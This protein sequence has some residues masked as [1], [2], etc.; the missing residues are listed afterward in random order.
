MQNPFKIFGLLTLL[1]S[2]SP[3]IS[4]FDDPKEAYE[5]GHAAMMSKDWLDA[6]NAFKK[7]S[8]S[9]KLKAAANYWQAYAHYQLNQNA[10]AKRLLERLIKTQEQSQWVDDAK[11]LLF[12]HGDGSEPAAYQQ[13]MDEE[14]KL[15]ALQ[16]LMFNQP[17][18]A[19]PKVQALL[20][21]TD[22]IRV[23]Q[24][25][26]Q[27]IG[28]SESEKVSDLLFEVIEK[29]KNV[30]L[31]RSAIQM[32]SLRNEQYSQ[33]KLAKLY[34]KTKNLDAK[35]AIIQGFIHQDNNNQLLKFLKNEKNPELSRQ[36]IQVLGIKGEVAT[37]KD[38]Y[39]NA[40]NDNRRA[41]LEALA[42]S[43][44]AEYLY[45]VI[46]NEKD[47]KLRQQAI[48]SLVMVDDD[49]M[50]DYLAKLY[51]R[52]KSD[53]EKDVIAN[54][55]VATDVDAAII[56]KLLKSE[57][58]KQRKERLLSTLM[59]M[60]EV[61]ALQEIYHQETDTETKAD[62]I[63]H[64]GAMDATDELMKLYNENP[65]N[66]DQEAFF[67]ALGMTSQELNEEF[68]LDRFREGNEN[69]KQSVLNALMM[70]DN[71]DAMLKLFKAEKDHEV[72]KMIIKMIGV[73]NPDALIEAIED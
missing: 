12:E 14:L 13:A 36:L 42:I 72:K 19:L 31:Q 65:D 22:S 45:Y 35:M 47:A 64:L 6:V 33:E 34:E 3:A 49:N 2:A 71:T 60:D 51:E 40:E 57:H 70:Q 7:A 11:V 46:D 61:T 54:M 8:E 50:G 53:S 1:V 68:L 10:Q 67:Q 24:N 4:D 23:K 58:N 16:Q 63:R 44:D 38:M 43:G 39:K 26:I 5:F 52:A 55:F 29:E 59:A 56:K 30:E 9:Q 28:L 32:L 21:K 18:K 25:A 48:Q 20:E 17:D 66:I 73:T 69:I 41:I 62:I 27:M 15:F 37:L